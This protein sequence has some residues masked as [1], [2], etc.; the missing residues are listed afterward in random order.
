[1]SYRCIRYKILIAKY[2][3]YFGKITYLDRWM[4]K[5]LK[6]ATSRPPCFNNW[7]CFQSTQDE[8]PS[9]PVYPLDIRQ[10]LKPPP[11]LDLLTDIRPDL[12]TLLVLEE[13]DLGLDLCPIPLGLSLDL[14]RGW[15]DQLDLGH[16]LRGGRFDLSMSLKE[17]WNAQGKGIWNTRLFGDREEIIQNNKIMI[18]II[19]NIIMKQ[20]FYNYQC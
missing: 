17:E 13:T 20:V 16:D 10:I 4:D 9:H 11:H 14:R 7:Y 6:F 19:N 5:Y 2:V 15:V 12:K 18:I 3:F 8:R 1:M